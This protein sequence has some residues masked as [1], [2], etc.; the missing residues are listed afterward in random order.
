M[1]TNHNRFLNIETFNVHVS[2]KKQV[3]QYKVNIAQRRKLRRSVLYK[4]FSIMQHACASQRIIPQIF[5]V[6][7]TVISF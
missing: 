2:I 3:S 1:S 6:Q 4:E 7:Q 5:V